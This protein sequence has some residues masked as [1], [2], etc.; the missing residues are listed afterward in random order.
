MFATHALLPGDLDGLVQPAVALSAPTKALGT[1]KNDG[2]LTMGEIMGIDLNADWV[3]L[4]ACNTG[5]ASGKGASAISGLGQ[6]FFYAGARS[7]LVSH[8]PVETTSAK[9]ITTGLFD[10]QT[11]DE[12]LTR[13]I[14]L[15]E[16]VKDLINNKTYKDKN[17]KDVFSYAHPV[18]W[19]PFTVVGD[20][21][22][23]LN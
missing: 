13:A 3:V 23:V 6:A 2:L 8:W 12:S 10:K 9:E 20:G 16:T 4:S 15:N 17:G 1:G 5:A 21:A 7:L 19:A 22:G 18:F 14:A 11:K